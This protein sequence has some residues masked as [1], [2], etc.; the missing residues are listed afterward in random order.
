M[1]FA[2]FESGPIDHSEGQAFSKRPDPLT[3]PS[4]LAVYTCKG[5]RT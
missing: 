1:P 5:G 3:T 2:A 4:I